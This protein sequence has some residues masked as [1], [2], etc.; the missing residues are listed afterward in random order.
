MA[1]LIRHLGER[2]G[3]VQHS[4]RGG[5]SFRQIFTPGSMAGVFSS[6]HYLPALLQRPLF[7]LTYP[8]YPSWGGLSRTELSQVAGEPK[9]NAAPSSG[10]PDQAA[11]AFEIAHVLE[12]A[13]TL[14]LDLVT[15]YL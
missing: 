14:D 1:V 11:W 15:L 3:E 7:G 4:T 8:D 9:P 12:Y 5:P 2:I 6:G 10:D 13:C